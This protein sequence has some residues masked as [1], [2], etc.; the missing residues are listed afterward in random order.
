MCWAVP[1]VSVN[2]GMLGSFCKMDP[3]VFVFVF[4]SVRIIY[5]IACF[6]DSSK[7]QHTSGSSSSLKPNNSCTCTHRIWASSC[8]CLW[9]LHCFQLL[10][11]VN[12]TTANGGLF[13]C[14][15]PSFQLFWMCSSEWNYINWKYKMSIWFFPFFCFETEWTSY[16]SAT[17]LTHYQSD[18][19]ESLSWLTV[20]E[21]TM[22]REGS[23]RCLPQT[24]K[25]LCHEKL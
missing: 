6:Q 14:L 5:L 16:F 7:R 21:Y 12:S 17:V 1:F 10:S 25:E 19:S 15:N 13:I 11:T 20:P 9:L 3:K 18:S 2:L 4:L 24:L 8:P 23:T 22:S